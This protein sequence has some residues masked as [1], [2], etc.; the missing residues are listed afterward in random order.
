AM[1]EPALDPQALWDDLQPLLDRELSRLPDKYRA[2]LVLCYLD[3]RTRK[4]AARQLNLPEGTVASRLATARAM[5][6][7]RLARAGLAVSGG[8]LAAV[9]SPSVVSAS[10]PACVASSTIKAAT[11]FAAGQA[12]AAGGISIH[13]ALL[14]EGV[15]KTMLLTKLKSSLLV[16]LTALVL[17]TGAAA[18]TH[19]VLA[20]NPAAPA[21]N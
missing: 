15:L 8:T 17:A 1:P 9:L 21:L 18:L 14:A 2:L 4:E 20:E 10:V 16:V 7:K 13:A 12:A 19:Q 5:L 3:G 6:A 11:L